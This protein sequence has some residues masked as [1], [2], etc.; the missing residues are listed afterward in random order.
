ML[1][2]ILQLVVLAADVEWNYASG[3]SATRP[4]NVECNAELSQVWARD[5]DLSVESANVS[6]FKG[7]IYVKNKEWCKQTRENTSQCINS[8]SSIHRVQNCL[9][10]ISTTE[11]VQCFR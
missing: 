6:D 10:D 11:I 8:S 4:I 5:T 3:S 9:A 7:S 2:A 1:T